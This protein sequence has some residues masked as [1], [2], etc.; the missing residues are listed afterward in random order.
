MLSVLRAHCISIKENW[1]VMNCI[2]LAGVDVRL[3]RGL[4]ILG[5]LRGQARPS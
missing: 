1:L 2:Q 4:T 5:P 3:I